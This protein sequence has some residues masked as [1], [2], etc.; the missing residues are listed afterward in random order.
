MKYTLKYGGVKGHDIN[1]LGSSGGTESINDKANGG[2]N[3]NTQ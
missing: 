2:K 1:K 3:V